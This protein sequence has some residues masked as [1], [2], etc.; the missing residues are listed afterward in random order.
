MAATDERLL[1]LDRRLASLRQ[2]HPELAQALD[3]HEQLA[4]ASLSSARPPQTQPFAIPREHLAARVREGVP[5]LHDQPVQI[6]LHFAADLFS[7][8][9]NAFQ[10]REDPE[11]A[12]RLDGIVA[13]A[14][15]GVL[16]PQRLFVEAFVQH[17]DH[18]AEMAAQAQVDAELLATIAVQS[19]APLLR[20]YADRLLPLLERLDDGSAESA[21]WH[22]GYCPVCGGWP[23]LAELRG[24]ELAQYLRCAG[25]GSAWRWRRI[26]CAYCE[27]DDFHTLQVLTIEAEQRFR[28]SVCE[29]CH[30]YLK[31]AN[32][33]DPPPAELLALDDVASLHLD[34]AAIERGYHRP[35]GSGFVIELAVPESLSESES[36]FES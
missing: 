27:N 33:F 11:L 9:V 7:R 21:A 24:V 17:H 32:S 26:R 14:T 15:G 1:L 8:L 4:R 29:R 3:L 30:G 2:S 36:E 20:A 13:A 22:H 35:M 18:L 6:D 5:L 25:C 12:A 23:L 28:I 31:V 34:V 16:D 19:V 10:Q